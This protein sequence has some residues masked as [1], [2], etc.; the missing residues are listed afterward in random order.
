MREKESYPIGTRLNQMFF[1][2]A[3]PWLMPIGL[4]GLSNKV[5]KLGLHT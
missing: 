2:S 3:L 1:Q 5:C 4:V